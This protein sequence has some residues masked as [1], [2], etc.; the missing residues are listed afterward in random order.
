MDREENF[1][2]KD[3]DRASKRESNTSCACHMLIRKEYWKEW[4]K[5]FELK[6]A[7]T[8]LKIKVFHWINR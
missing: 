8:F 2:L 7:E 1:D 6:F 3:A 5:Q 4:A